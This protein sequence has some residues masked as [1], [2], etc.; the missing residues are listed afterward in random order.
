M[1]SVDG[2]L[3]V[4]GGDP[5]AHWGAAAYARDAA[6]DWQAAGMLPLMSADSAAEAD[7]A[8]LDMA[9]IMSILRPPVR[10][11]ALDGRFAAVAARGGSAAASKVGVA[12]YRRDA[13]T[14]RWMEDGRLL[15]VEGE[16]GG[17]RIE[18]AR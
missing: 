9:G 18:L 3:L 17:C 6:G 7:G 14:G 15:P 16:V 13:A 5:K 12:I 1:A 10:L 11:V 2:F 8:P 4:G